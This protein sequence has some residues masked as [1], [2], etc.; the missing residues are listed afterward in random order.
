MNLTKS[1]KSLAVLAAFSCLSLSALAGPLDTPGYDTFG[2]LSVATF[3][4]SG[5][6]ND[7]VAQSSVSESGVLL[8][9][10]ATQRYANPTV[11]NDGAG[12]FYALAGIDQ[13]NSTSISG[14][15]ARWNFGFYIDNGN[16]TGNTYQLFM[17]VDSSLSEDFRSFGAGPV[18][19][20]YQDSWNLGFDGFESALGYVFNPNE[21]GEYTFALTAHDSSGTLIARTAIIVAVDADPSTVPEPGTL[22][23]LGMGL[24]GLAA[25]RR[26]QKQ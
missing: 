12:Y 6:P 9:L 16:A 19:G 3:G 23:L 8:G 14:Q 15:Y 24:L 26:R 13:T 22:A 4:G 2:P 18:S 5:I 25:A 10:T 7:A 11:T 20:V 1:S 21:T 17:D